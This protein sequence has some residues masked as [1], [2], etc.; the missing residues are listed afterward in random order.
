MK[1][2]DGIFHKVFD[3]IAKEYP[4]IQ[5]DHYIIDIGTAR[6][7][8]KPEIFDVIVTMNLYGDIISDV[9]AETSGSVGLAGS[10]NIGTN[11]AMFEAIHGSAPDIAGQDLANP[12]GLINAAVMMLVHLGQNEVASKIRN[13]LYKTIEDGIHT[14]DIYNTATSKKKVGT[15]EFTESVISNLGQKPS[16]LPIAN[17]SSGDNK[18]EIKSEKV[19]SVT[20]KK[21]LIGF[22]L[23]LDWNK[24]FNDLLAELKT[25]ESDVLEVK[26]ISA[27]GLLL[28]P[29]TDQHMMP[30]YKKGLTV[31]RFIGKGITGKSSNEILD[32]N[33]T[34][35]HQ[36]IIDMLAI[37]DKK[38]FDFVKYE[39]LYLFDG[40]PGYTSGQGE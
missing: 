34:I 8:A 6:L 3:E 29:L 16:Q 17:Y 11:Y 37:L 14:A 38:K 5:N 26:M 35:L 36:D 23:F 12:T 31:L 21:S 9:V 15:K 28:W 4:Q 10:A 1:M 25:M 18:T 13:A 32:A 39:G 2:T 40:K 20:S 30:I 7:A 24:E 27:K 22:D 33:K 19:A